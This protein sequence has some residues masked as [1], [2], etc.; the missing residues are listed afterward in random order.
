MQAFLQNAFDEGILPRRTASGAQIVRRG[1][2][3]RTVVSADGVLSA[4]GR[5]WQNI[6]G[7]QLA[8]LPFD[9][10][11]TPMREGSVEYI[12]VRGKKTPRKNI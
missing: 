3:Y 9:T 1:N 2:N 5:V 7:T 12:F 4:S 6:S 10:Q 11:Q 8:T